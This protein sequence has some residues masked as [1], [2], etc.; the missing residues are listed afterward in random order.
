[1]LTPEQIKQMRAK[2]GIPEQG[3]NASSTISA[4]ERIQKLRGATIAKETAV[5]KTGGG[6][7]EFGKGIV[8]AGKFVA[9]DLVGL[10][11]KSDSFLGG[12]FQ[13]IFGSRGVAG[14]A[15]APAKLIIGSGTKG[16]QA[17][18]EQLAL[19]T[20]KVAENLANLPDNDP[21]REQLL[22][23]LEQN[24]ETLGITDETL[25]ELRTKGETGRQAAANIL[26][27][28]VTLAT[29]GMGAPASAGIAAL[30]GAAASGAVSVAS[31]IEENK[32]AIQI[33]K[34]AVPATLAGA[35]VGTGAYK[36]GQ[37]ASAFFEKA[38]ERL[39]QSALKQSAQDL[40]KEIAEQAP[41]LSQQLLKQGVKGGNAKILSESL[42]GIQSG[43]Q[44]I[45]TV[46]K[47]VGKQTVPS[48]LIA[49]SLDDIGRRMSNVYG[50][51][52]NEPVL[53]FKKAL[54]ARGK[55]IT[56]D[57]L[58]QLKRD[59]YGELAKSAFNA[60][61][62]LSTTNEILRTTASSIVENMAR[63]APKLDAAIKNQQMW[64]RA[65]QA[66][67]G[68]VQRT[69]KTNVMG[70]SDTILAGT[71]LSTGS[72]NTIMAGVGRKVL[73]TTAAKTTAAVTIDKISKVLENYVPK[74]IIG[75]VAKRVASQLT[76]EAMTF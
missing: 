2:I 46:L 55:A 7:V 52:A 18:R 57:D 67:E 33:A 50:K 37:Y 63:V 42:V 29:F 30:E 21:R 24:K 28:G 36:L 22:K 45:Q 15:Q 43:E 19:V 62:S 10:E 14:I 71:G 1:M 47:E 32:S 54:L 75:D 65:A 4:Q 9:K 12:L 17:S 76:G 31:G 58:F 48:K 61:A 69:A 64:I 8:D 72:I 39:Y 20:K 11:E 13:N 60:D 56:L 26:R 51:G 23:V 40:K 5:D 49:E 41:N 34:E 66:M 68:N 16:V 6:L 70:L 73:E 35:V 44:Q 59:I 53:A 38:P 25:T 3:V 27:G 74:E